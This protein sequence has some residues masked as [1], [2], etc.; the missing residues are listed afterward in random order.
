[1]LQMSDA[2]KLLPTAMVSTHTHMHAC[3]YTH[4]YISAFSHND[5]TF[6]PTKWNMLLWTPIKCQM[7]NYYS[8]T[9]IVIQYFMIIKNSIACNFTAMR[10][11]IC[12]G[13]QGRHWQFLYDVS[14]SY[15]WKAIDGSAHGYPPFL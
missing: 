3:T 11:L 6:S 14:F 1:M 12:I 7:S 10:I 13:A 8:S 2:I 4:Y 9:Y 5:R 15:T